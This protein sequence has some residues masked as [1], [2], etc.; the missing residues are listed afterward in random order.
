MSRK[1]H[2]GTFWGNISVLFL[3]WDGD[4]TGVITIIIFKCIHF[5]DPWL[6]SEKYLLIN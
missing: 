6:K 2:E 5:F 4:I 3:G 1:G